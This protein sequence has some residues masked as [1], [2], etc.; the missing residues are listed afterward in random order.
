MAASRSA[1]EGVQ[2]LRT[3]IGRHSASAGQDHAGMIH[4]F[5]KQPPHGKISAMK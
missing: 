1:D 4:R 5:R 3:H 2:V